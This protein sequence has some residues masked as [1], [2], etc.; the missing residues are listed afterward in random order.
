M[1]NER[2]IFFN[3][4]LPSESTFFNTRKRAEATQSVERDRRSEVRI[5][6][7]KTKRKKDFLRYI[8]S[9]EST[10][11]NTRKRAEATQSVERDVVNDTNK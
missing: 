11:F 9:S 7:K 5:S 2:R 6:E 8:L 3:F 1:Q 4:A 10:F